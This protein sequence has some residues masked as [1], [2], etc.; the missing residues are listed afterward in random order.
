MEDYLIK[1]DEELVLLFQG[2]DA[3]VEDVLIERYREVVKSRAR[4][5]FIVGAD[6]E[7]VI[8]EGMIGLYKAMREYSAERGA[9][10][11]T[12]AKL[13]I[14][15][16][17]E[18]AIQQANRQKNK[19]LNNSVSVDETISE[20][21]SETV[22]DNLM[23]ADLDDPEKMMIL[24]DLVDEILLYGPTFLS[25]FESQVFSLYLSGRDYQKIASDLGKEPKQIDNALQRIK[26]K[27]KSFINESR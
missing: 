2:G 24:R 12:F 17:I 21:G 5:F 26:K 3:E 13:C 9:S 15:R 19:A 18:K 23:G 11:S 8:Q 1:K 6:N 25:K 22:L 10:F 16:Q 27:V 4:L 7:D 14:T 20:E